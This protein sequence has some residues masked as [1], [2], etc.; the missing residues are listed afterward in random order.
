ML[1]SVKVVVESI[2][3]SKSSNIEFM[4]ICICSNLTKAKLTNCLCLFVCLSIY[5]SGWL[6][7]HPNVFFTRT[8]KMCE[9]NLHLSQRVLPKISMQCNTNTIL[10]RCTVAWQTIR[11]N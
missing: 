3:V 7:V 2:N 8:R 11:T 9:N 4:K 6:D 1:S 5:L 10:S